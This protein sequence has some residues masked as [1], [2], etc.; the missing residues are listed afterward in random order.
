METDRYHVP[1]PK[2][3]DTLDLRTRIGKILL[4]TFITILSTTVITFARLTK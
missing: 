2:P 3:R 4:T 1:K